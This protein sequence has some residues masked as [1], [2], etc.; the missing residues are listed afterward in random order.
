[1]PAPYISEIKYLGGASVDFV[2]VALDAGTSTANIEIIIYHP[3]GSVRT[4]NTLGALDNTI[5]GTDVYI[6]DVATSATFNGLHKNGAVAIAVNGVVTGFYSFNSAVTA[7]AGPAS[8]TTS[9]QVGTTASGGSLEST[10][11][12][13]YTATTTPT[14][15]TVPCFVTGTLIETDT[16]LRV[17]EGLSVGD[18]VMTLDNGFQKLLWVGQRDLAKCERQAPENAAVLIPA[19]AFGQGCPSHTLMVSRNHRMVLSGPTIELL[20][21]APE[22]LVA[23]KSLVGHAGV[24]NVPLLSGLAYHHLLFDSHEIVLSNGMA[25]ESLHLGQM[26]LLGFTPRVRRALREHFRGTF[27]AATARMVLTAAEAHTAVACFTSQGL[28]RQHAS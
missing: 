8:G 1:M 27:K 13:T 7:T 15:A 26:A 24:R 28:T 11:G 22:V 4:T 3:N 10:D 23:A 18:N 6:I 25:S 9:T 19:D 20:Y 16:G 21:G 5:A 14:P 12:V 17:V 2:E